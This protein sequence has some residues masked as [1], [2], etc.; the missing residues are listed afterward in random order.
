V[1]DIPIPYLIPGDRITKPDGTLTN[2]FVNAFNALVLRTGTQHFNAISGIISGAAQQVASTAAAIAAINTATQAAIA[3][4]GSTTTS[5]DADSAIAVSS[6]TF[7]TVMTCSVTTTGAGNYVITGVLDIT[8]ITAASPLS[9]ALSIFYGD[10]QI[11]ENPNAHVL[12]SGTFTI[13]TTYNGGEGGSPFYI[14][15]IAFGTALPSAVSYADNETGATTISLQLRRASGS[16]TVT[17]LTGSLLT[18][19]S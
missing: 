8:A 10:W 12:A 6:G 4:S 9:T 13:T 16:N 7:A 15:E 19:W 5:S 18:V 1:T 17:G 2:E 11:I 3:A 14:N